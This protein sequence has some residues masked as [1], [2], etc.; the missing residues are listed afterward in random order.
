M[1]MQQVT[2][3]VG[4]APPRRGLQ[5]TVLPALSRLAEIERSF[6]DPFAGGD[7]AAG[8]QGFFPS[9]YCNANA[10][11]GGMLDLLV[12][13]EQRF[14]GG[15]EMRPVRFDFLGK[16]SVLVT[17]PRH[18]QQVFKDQAHFS[19]STDPRI[20]ERFQKLLGFNLVSA[21]AEAWREVRPRT[22]AFLSGRP[23]AEYGELMRS[24]MEE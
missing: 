5:R 6:A 3:A 17:N 1:T 2:D 9:L 24:V 21:D 23:L 18:I 13:L 19:P 4:T 15:A 7:E 12:E 10:F 11:A 16:P 22:A 14:G 20:R 8:Y